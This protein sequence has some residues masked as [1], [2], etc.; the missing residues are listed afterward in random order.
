MIPGP[1]PPTPPSPPRQP[2]SF[3]SAQPIASSTS[4]RTRQLTGQ[5]EVLEALERARSY[6][7]ELEGLQHSLALGGGMDR[8]VP[9]DND[10][11]IV[12]P[13]G[14]PVFHI[15][16]PGAPSPL[17]ALGDRSAAHDYEQVF[18]RPVPIAPVSSHDLVVRN[19]GAGGSGIAVHEDV[20]HHSADL[21][22]LEDLVNMGG[23]ATLLEQTLQAPPRRTGNIVPWD[24][25][26]RG[27]GG[28]T[29]RARRP[30]CAAYFPRLVF[31][32]LI[33]ACQL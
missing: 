25:L 30:I 26:P 1:P 31:I 2:D 21:L 6:V 17:T 32:H 9:E 27:P 19:I 15:G 4:S 5:Q 28:G 29:R 7:R 14:A 10:E 8:P 16:E 3:E 11:L 12:A 20:S 22:G 33:M 13:G 23:G 24:P 18:E